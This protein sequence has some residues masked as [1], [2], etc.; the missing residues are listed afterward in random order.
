VRTLT[1]ILITVFTAAV[2]PNHYIV[3]PGQE[4]ERA[5]GISQNALSVER[6]KR[7]QRDRKRGTKI[8]INRTQAREIASLHTLCAS[9]F[10]NGLRAST[11]SF[12]ETTWDRPARTKY[13]LSNDKLS[14]NQRTRLRKS[15]KKKQERRESLDIY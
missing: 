1:R 8:L 3:T 2:S 6:T 12:E 9:C 4:K 11:D 13:V 15:W 5:R 7:N 14:L 10:Q